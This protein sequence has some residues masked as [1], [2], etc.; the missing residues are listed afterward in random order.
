MVTLPLRIL[1]QQTHIHAI[2][3]IS[4]L[5]SCRWIFVFQILFCSSSA[6]NFK[7]HN[8]TL[9]V[10]SRKIY[11]WMYGK[12]CLWKR[13]YRFKSF[14][15]VPNR[16]SEANGFG[17]IANNFEWHLVQMKPP[18]EYTLT[19][20][21][22]STSVYSVVVFSFHVH[23]ATQ[24]QLYLIDFSCTKLFVAVSSHFTQHQTLFSVLLIINSIYQL[25]FFGNSQFCS[26]LL[27]E[28]QIMNQLQIHIFQYLLQNI[29]VRPSLRSLYTQKH[30]TFVNE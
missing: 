15:T 8:R 24:S 25:L 19:S 3:S 29:F 30:N 17:K 9:I 1:D 11:S 10:C 23:C 22:K 18:R 4:I 2:A 5:S 26:T 12:L 14:E 27:K 28:L 21:S 13:K 16:P 20:K 6:Q 7:I